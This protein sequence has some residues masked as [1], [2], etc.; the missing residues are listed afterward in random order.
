MFLDGYLGQLISGLWVT[1][2][3]ALASLALGLFLGIL[4]ALGE[5][6]KTKCIKYPTMAITLLIRGLP[7]LVVLFTLYFGSAIILTKL[8]GHYQAFNA[9]WAGVLGKKQ[10]DPLNILLVQYFVL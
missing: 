8:F 10:L 7:E 3:L 5:M 1:I 2:Q 9:F 4:G 6:S